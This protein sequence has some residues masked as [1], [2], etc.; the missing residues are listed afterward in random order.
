MTVCEIPQ[1]TFPIQTKKIICMTVSDPIFSSPCLTDQN[2]I[3][4][5]EILIM[6]LLMKK[7]EYQNDGKNYRKGRKL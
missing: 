5:R 7:Y 2:Y 6:K 3:T 1:E 4:K